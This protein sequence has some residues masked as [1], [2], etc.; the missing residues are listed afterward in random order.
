MQHVTEQDLQSDDIHKQFEQLD[1]SLNEC[2]SDHNFILQMLLTC[3]MRRIR[4]IDLMKLMKESNNPEP[5]D[6]SGLV[7]DIKEGKMF[8]MSIWGLN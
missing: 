5:I 4:R 6:E 2:L 8:M 1:S 3:Y 7:G